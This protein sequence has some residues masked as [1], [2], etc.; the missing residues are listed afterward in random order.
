[1]SGTS[2]PVFSG[3]VLNDELIEKYVTIDPFIKELQ[4]SG[5]VSYGLSSFGYDIRVGSKFKFAVEPTKNSSLRLIDPKKI[6][7][8]CFQTVFATEG[9]VDLPPHSFALAETVEYFEI[10]DNVLAICLGKSTYARCGMVVHMTPAEPGWAGKLTLELS[11]TTPLPLRVYA[12][13]GIAQLIFIAGVG[14]ERCKVSYADRQ[15][16]YQGQTGLT[17]PF[18]LESK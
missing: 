18:V 11:N 16:K 12:N 15:G 17:L 7:V 8:S 13:E 5:K 2:V 4:T 9:Y 10:P 1:M 3:G 14:G 6:D